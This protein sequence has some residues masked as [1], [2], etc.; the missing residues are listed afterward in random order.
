MLTKPDW[1]C[2]SGDMLAVRHIH[3]YRHPTGPI[4]L[5]VVMINRWSMSVFAEMRLAEDGPGMHQVVSAGAPRGDIFVRSTVKAPPRALS[6][7]PTP[8][9]LASIVRP[10]L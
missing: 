2:S 7:Q 1:T 3:T 8:I 4:L 6:S 5:S 9:E 10:S